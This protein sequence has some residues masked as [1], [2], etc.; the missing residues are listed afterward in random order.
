MKNISFLFSFLFLLGISNLSA[1]A[2][3]QVGNDIDGAAAG[4]MSGDAVS[5]S[6]DGKRVAILAP[7]NDGGGAAGVSGKR[8]RVDTTGGRF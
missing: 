4:D 7:E 6:A 1:Q 3:A 2:W 8:G 5:I